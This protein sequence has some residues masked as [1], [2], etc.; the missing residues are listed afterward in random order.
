MPAQE[1]VGLEL[2]VGEVAGV[3]ERAGAVVVLVA[4]EVALEPLL[5]EIVDGSDRLARRRAGRRPGRTTTISSWPGT[6]EV[7][8][9]PKRKGRQRFACI[10]G[11]GSA[12]RSE[13]NNPRE[14]T[15]VDVDRGLA[16]HY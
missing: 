6:R 12:G 9:V 11:S 16:P 14:H 7:T 10:A 1:H 15:V 8:L 4:E 5:R 2:E 3:D 13:G